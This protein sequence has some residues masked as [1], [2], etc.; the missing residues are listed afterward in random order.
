MTGTFEHLTNCISLCTFVERTIFCTEVKSVRMPKIIK[1]IV[2][3]SLM[4]KK[5]CLLHNGLFISLVSF[6]EGFEQ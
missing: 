4:K 3:S 5:M 2:V 1:V 6:K